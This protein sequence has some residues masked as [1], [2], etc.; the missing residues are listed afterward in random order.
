MAKERV[1]WDGELNTKAVDLLL[2]G[3]KICVVPT[4]VGYIIATAD[5]EGLERKFAVK[6]R[7]RNKPAVVLIG[8]MEELDEL[9]EMNDEIRDYYQKHWDRDILMGCILPWKESGLKYIPE[10]GDA[11]QL[12]RD[13]R[14]TSCFVVKYGKAAEQISKELWEKEKKLMFA[15]SANPSGRGNRGK[16]AGIGEKIDSEADL[17]IE[18]DDYVTSIQPNASEETRWEQGVMVS[19]VTEDG[20]LIPEQKGQRMVTPCPILIRKGVYLPEILE[21]LSDS[22][23]SWDF[24]QGFYY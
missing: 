20:T 4:K 2:E 11:K 22:F 16:V 10:E 19:F 24:R 18:A 9:A 15:S 12:V 21:I 23:L 8:S 1:H 17:V 7:K 13:A 3:G 6:D 5:S 14:G